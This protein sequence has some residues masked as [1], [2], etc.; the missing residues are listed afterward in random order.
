MVE[1]EAR[2]AATRSVVP[3]D[4]DESQLD[5]QLVDG[6]PEEANLEEEGN[7]GIPEARER[8]RAVEM[9]TEVAKESRHHQAL[10][11]KR[12]AQQELRIQ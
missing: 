9:A 5:V 8:I 3:V 2:R 6:A 7:D 4:S 1:E 12:Q 10:K 11:E